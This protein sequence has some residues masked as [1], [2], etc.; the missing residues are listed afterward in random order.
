MNR[1]NVEDLYPLTPLQQGM[2][3]HALH[4]P[5][6]DVYA[7]QVV[8]ALEGEVDPG[9]F[10]RAWQAVVDR[11]PALRTGFVWERV[12][13]PMQIVFRRV[14]LPVRAEDWS[15]LEPG[16]RER[17]WAALVEDDRADG[18]DLRRAPLLR[19]ALARFGEREWRLLV[20]QHHLLLDGWSL[21]LVFGD[22]AAAYRA[23]LDGREA[24]LPRRPAF[25]DYVAW[26]GKQEEGAAEAFWRRR[27]E[28]LDAPTPLPLDRAPARA[29]RPAEEHGQETAPIPADLVQRIVGAARRH[30]VT[31]STLAQA[32]WAAVLARYAGEGDVV[33]GTTVSGRPPELPGVEEMVGLFINTLP[34]RVRVPSSGSV[35]GWLRALQD[36]QSQARVHELSPLSSV[37]AWSGLGGDLPLFETLFVYENFPLGAPGGGGEPPP[38]AVTYARAAERT[39]YPL[40]LVVAP[41]GDGMRATATYDALRLDPPRVRALLAAYE[42]VLRRLA[43]GDDDAATALDPLSAAERALVVEA[44]NRTSRPYPRSSV[45]RL[46]EAHAASSPGSPALRWDGGEL[47]YGELNARANRLARRLRALGVGPE[48]RV[49]VSLDRSAEV[50]VA[51]L[52]IL[53]AGGAYVPLDRE[54]PSA[55]LEH[56]RRDAGVRVVIAH[57]AEG[58]AEWAGDARVVALEGEREAIEAESADDLREVEVDPEG[59]AYVVYTSGSTGLPKGTGVPHRAVVR[60][61]RGQDYAR[62][63]A[64][65]VVLQAAPVAFDASTFELWGALLNGGCVAVYPPEAPE[66]RALGGFLRRHGVTAAW[67]TAGLFH[68]AVDEGLPGF[69]GLRQLLAGGD[70]L[71][72][73]HVARAMELLPEARLVDGYGPTEATTFPAC[74]TIRGEDLAGGGPIPIG[75]PLANAR[76]Y[77]LDG[78]MRPVPAGAPGELYVAGDGLA[79]GYLGKPGLTAEKFVPDP[80]PGEPGGRLY[81]TGDRVRWRESGVLEFLGRSDQ[82]VKVR[83]FRIEP[84][85]IEAALRRHESVTDCV[86]VARTEA[87]ETRLV[88]Y[89]VGGV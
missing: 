8:M 49:G 35:G 26:V 43:A 58:I 38:F 57:D 73:P 48:S 52:A 6:A 36:E 87:G 21:G 5:H 63:G 46:F 85:E 74:H 84:G 70:V 41:S 34:V 32:A 50:I 22:F 55:R 64:D 77:V 33:F 71:S 65:E 12:R 61:V 27:L 45:H 18:W 3:F 13:Q 66:P 25:R 59:L 7:E 79:R 14:A 9:A 39:N 31:A 88:A 86:V 75:R 54:Y 78:E 80:F 10:A 76:C 82:Q 53:K 37:R 68:R 28:G 16:E 72:P 2:L 44:W 23:E 15:G 69:E 24:A 81:R 83:G 51:L 1:E 89:I 40:S 19:L 60:L 47:A 56:M 29:G 17:R 62:F 67:L 20:S 11:T 30:R 4:S 42:T